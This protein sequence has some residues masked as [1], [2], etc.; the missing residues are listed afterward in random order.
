MVK[1]DY[2]KNISLFS[3]F[4]EKQI[5][6]LAQIAKLK[7]YDKNVTLFE[8]GE[9][10][11][12]LFVIK[13]GEVVIEKQP[14]LKGTAPVATLTCKDGDFFG[15]LS[16]FDAGPRSSTARTVTKT[17]FIIFQKKDFLKLLKSDPLVGSELFLTL[18]KIIGQR[19]QQTNKELI[20]FYETGKLLSLKCESQQ[21]FESL[22]EIAIQSTYANCGVIYIQNFTT[23]LLEPVVIKGYK[24]KKPP[25]V[26]IYT[27][28]GILSLVMKNAEALLIKNLSEEP[29]FK[30]LKS[31][32]YEHDTMLL[33][34]LGIGENI[35]GV[36]V[37]I[38][39]RIATK[40]VPFGENDLGLIVAISRQVGAAIENIELHKEEENRLRIKREYLSF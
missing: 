40:K 32:G 38:D 22:L 17:D 39:K 8:E 12:I 24:S 37:L 21:L 34:P 10:G 2:L 28:P 9:E 31:Q 27:Q 13:K 14:L 26:D 18:I 6:S 19:I 4:K 35:K 30:K 20:A 25:A 36:L 29:E 7:T 23:K 3:S 15:E 11:D 33:V 1:V 16:L 5:V